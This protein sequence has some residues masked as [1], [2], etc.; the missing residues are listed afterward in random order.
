MQMRLIVLVALALVVVA[1][2]QKQ[3]ASK[4]PAMDEAEKVG[5]IAGHRAGAKAG[6]DAG[7][8][9]GRLAGIKAIRD[10]NPNPPVPTPVPL[11]IVDADWEKFMKS[12]PGAVI[13][14]R[15]FDVDDNKRWSQAEF[16]KGMTAAKERNF[17]APDYDL[18]AAWTLL[19][20]TETGEITI[21]EF[22]GFAARTHGRAAR[23]LRHHHRRN[24]TAAER[25]TGKQCRSIFKS[26]DANKDNMLSI[27]EFRV[28][29]AGKIP[30]D[31]VADKFA[32]LPQVENQISFRSFSAICANLWGLPGGDSSQTAVTKDPCASHPCRRRKG[33]VCVPDPKQCITTKCKQ[34]KCMR[35]SS[36][37]GVAGGPPTNAYSGCVAYFKQ[38]DQDQSRFLSY[39]EFDTSV[40]EKQRTGV[41]SRDI[42]VLDAWNRF[43]KNA[44]GEVDIYEFIHFCVAATT[45]A[46]DIGATAREECWD[47]FTHFDADRSQDLSARE[48]W[49][50][51]R[52]ARRQGHIAADLNIRSVWRA[53][54]KTKWGTLE[55]GPFIDFCMSI[56]K[57]DDP[58]VAAKDAQPIPSEEV[59]DD[60]G[61]I[62]Y[63]GDVSKSTV[64][65]NTANIVFC[66]NA[67]KQGDI[68]NDGKISLDEFRQICS[69]IGNSTECAKPHRFFKKYD[70]NKDRGL[71]AKEFIKACKGSSVALNAGAAERRRRIKKG[72]KAGAH[73]GRKAGAIAGEKAGRQ[74]GGFAAANYVHGQSFIEEELREVREGSRLHTLRTQQEGAL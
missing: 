8:E 4:T 7:A 72:R 25:Y 32:A 13:F 19:A 57:G 23:G 62:E 15:E 16:M 71:E 43:E 64:G 22:I 51:M 41:Y 26:F 63:G 45:D 18:V 17:I 58:L 61:G 48:F 11:P 6:R 3:N 73:A 37:G 33:T 20:K 74:A 46:D 29:V 36:T 40:K 66:K 69:T 49:K 5:A 52:R 44:K 60:A 53:L 24:K 28:A 56:S 31:Q 68:N 2:A 30:D 35:T 59:P 65:I 34:Y 1:S 14:F 10:E 47:V 50:G 42:R 54:P 39:V 55:V 21:R 38:A 70:I 27:S 9:A 12:D 67:F